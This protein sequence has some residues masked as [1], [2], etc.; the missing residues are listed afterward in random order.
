M[1]PQKRLHYMQAS[2]GND[3]DKAADAGT[4][5]AQQRKE[6]KQSLKRAFTSETLLP[7]YAK[8]KA[9]FKALNPMSGRWKQVTGVQQ[10]SAAENKRVT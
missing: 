3:F 2:G 10:N 6:I 7:S 4:V 1:I 9:V 8:K 5:Q